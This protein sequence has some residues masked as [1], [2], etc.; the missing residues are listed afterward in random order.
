M[1]LSHDIGALS[2][3]AAGFGQLCPRFREGSIS[4]F[5][6]YYGRIAASKIQDAYQHPEITR[7]DLDRQ[8]AFCAENYTWSGRAAEC[9]AILSS[10][11][12]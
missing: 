9:E 11:A 12:R 6:D 2:E 10:V 8:Q 7:R 4:E 3:T 5:P 1:I